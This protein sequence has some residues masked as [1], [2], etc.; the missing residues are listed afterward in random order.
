MS[1]DEQRSPDRQRQAA[2]LDHLADVPTDVLTE[3]VERDGTCWWEVTSGDPPDIA[4][5]EQAPDRALAARLCAGC[6]VQLECLELELNTAGAATT[7]VWGAL[8]EDDRRALHPV[9]QAR[10]QD[11]RRNGD[12]QR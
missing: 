9:W 6:P 8:G 11:Q 3:L 12:E 5:D 10:R 1:R 7:G 2:G 4:D